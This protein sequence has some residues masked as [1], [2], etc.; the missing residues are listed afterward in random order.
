MRQADRGEHRQAARAFAQGGARS[1][2][3]ASCAYPARLRRNLPRHGFNFIRVVVFSIVP[4]VLDSD[5]LDRAK[6]LNDGIV[7]AVRRL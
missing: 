1:F 3:L 5:E 2:S 6:V 4:P 7:G